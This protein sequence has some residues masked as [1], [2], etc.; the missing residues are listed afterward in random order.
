MSSSLAYSEIDTNNTNNTNKEGELQK[1]SQPKRNNATIRRRPQINKPNNQNVSDMLKIINDTNGYESIQ[2]NNDE[3]E[4]G[5]FNPPPRPTLNNKNPTF[6]G[7][8]NKNQNQT[9]IDIDPEQPV[10]VNPQNI[11][12]VKNDTTQQVVQNRVY[13]QPMDSYEGYQD[14]P[15]NYSKQFYKNYVPYF[16]QNGY[17]NLTSNSNQNK[18]QLLEKLNY[19]I[20]LLEE[21]KD[22]KTGH[23][24]E[25]VILYSF[26]GIFIIF[27]VD[28]FARAGKYTR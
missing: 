15:K 3:S 24:I 4:L 22:E 5:D 27:I 17:T 19:M 14:M 25:E 12:Q 26:L 13:P 9:T 2:D 7:N 10:S 21:Q 18:D 6:E 8:K 20:H 11:D 1:N 23:V 16:N 28:S